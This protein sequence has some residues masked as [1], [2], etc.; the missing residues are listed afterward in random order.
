MRYPHLILVCALVADRDRVERRLEHLLLL[1]H[2]YLSCVGE[3]CVRGETH[4]ERG[5][6][7]EGFEAIEW[8]RHERHPVVIGGIV[9]AHDGDEDLVPRG[10]S[11]GRAGRLVQACTR[12]AA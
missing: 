11:G 3:S 12:R 7:F 6:M 9:L 8:N 2:L 10:R 1:L 5:Q 4:L